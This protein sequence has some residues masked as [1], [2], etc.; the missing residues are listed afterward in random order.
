MKS[1]EK[2]SGRIAK[3]MVSAKKMSSKPSVATK[4]KPW[5]AR[6]RAGIKK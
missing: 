5:A 6:H 4:N 2:E 1:M 3:P